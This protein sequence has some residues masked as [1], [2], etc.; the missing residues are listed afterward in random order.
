MVFKDKR[1]PL[2]LKTRHF[3]LSALDTDSIKCFCSQE[4]IT[5]ML[6]VDVDQRFSAVQVLEHP[7]VNVS[8]SLPSLYLLLN[9]PFSNHNFPNDVASCFKCCVCVCSSPSN[10]PEQFQDLSLVPRGP[11]MYLCWHVF[12][13]SLAQSISFDS[14]GTAFGGGGDG[15]AHGRHPRPCNLRSLVQIRT[16]SINKTEQIFWVSAAFASFLTKNASDPRVSAPAPGFCSAALLKPACAHKSPG[17]LTKMQMVMSEMWR[18]RFLKAPRCCCCYLSA[19][20]WW[21]SFSCERSLQSRVIIFW[22]SLS[23][24]LIWFVLNHHH[25]KY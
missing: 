23:N 9:L 1:E 16:E 25:N 8:D 11:L 17:G 22:S 5:M 2:H 4:L 19:R 24:W 3:L 14:D 13:R 20:I 6:L 10:M 18:S 7:W 21:H 15:I 12:S